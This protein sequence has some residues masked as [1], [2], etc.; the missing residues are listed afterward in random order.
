MICPNMRA[1]QIYV[2]E[3]T[4]ALIEA[5]AADLLSD[6]RVDQVIWRTRPDPRRRRRLH[7]CDAARTDGFRSRR[8]R[9]DRGTDVFGGDWTWTG[10]PA[11]LAL[12]AGRAD[13][14]LFGLPER[15]RAD[16]RRA[17]SR[18]ERRDLGHRE[19][20]LRVRSAGWGGARRR[21]L[22]RRTARARFAQPG[23]HG[24]RAARAAAAAPHA[25]RWISRRSACSCSACR[26][27]IAWAIRA[28]C[29]SGDAR[30]RARRWRHRDRPGA[31]APHLAVLR[32]DPLCTGLRG[33]R[34]RHALG[35]GAAGLLALA[36]AAIG[37]L[38][39]V[40][41][42]GPHTI[43]WATTIGFLVVG[44]VGNRL[45][46]ARNRANQA[47]ARERGATARHTRSPAEIRG[48]AA[49]RAAGRGRRPAFGRCRAQ[50]QQPP[51][52]DDGLHRRAAGRGWRR[53]VAPY[54][55]DRD[56]PR[57][58]TRRGAGPADARLRPPARSEGGA[59]RRGRHGGQPP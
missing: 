48:R 39:I 11:A 31:H 53:G 26:C 24:G 15:L 28:P 58:R 51:H 1:A 32:A 14:S 27:A 6:S 17:R 59:R 34:D 52:G 33:R 8:R 3:S 50:L 49:P 16:R 29:R 18:S 9:L 25:A 46:A 45:I 23:H 35:S 10:D 43:N 47:L 42:T 37:G 20:R 4:P 22:A 57:H 2:R 21:R 7:R 12:E 5:I 30:L 56:S 40:P 44:F 55:A 36:L 38:A 19:A 13:D 54:G 41:D